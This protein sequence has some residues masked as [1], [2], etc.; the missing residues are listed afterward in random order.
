MFPHTVTIYHHFVENGTDVY[1]KKVLDGCYWIHKASQAAA[2]KGTEKTDSY[3]VIFSPEQ[4]ARYGVYWDVYAGARVVKGS[5]PDIT[6]WKE[7]KGDVM[8]VKAVE[9]NICGSSV[10]NITL[11][12]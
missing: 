1:S 12:G 6:S 4:T 3:T 10:D 2:G 9:E 8:T 5:G 11:T 7:L